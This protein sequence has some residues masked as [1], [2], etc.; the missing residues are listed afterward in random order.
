MHRG[1]LEE[2]PKKTGQVLRSPLRIPPLGGGGRDPFTIIN[3]RQRH[4]LAQLISG[5]SFICAILSRSTDPETI[6]IV[7]DA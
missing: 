6:D 4:R 1:R 3:D 2:A 7:N 5:D